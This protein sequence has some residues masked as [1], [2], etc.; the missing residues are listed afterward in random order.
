MN[1]SRIDEPIMQQGGVRLSDLLVDG[2]PN[3][4]EVC[5][6]TEQRRIMNQGLKA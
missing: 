1:R 6:R 2:R 3:P 5:V 4:E